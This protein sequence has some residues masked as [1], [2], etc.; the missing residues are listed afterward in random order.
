MVS[1]P[2]SVWVVFHRNPPFSL[3]RVSPVLSLRIDCCR[4]CA[5]DLSTGLRSASAITG[6]QDACSS[7]PTTIRSRR[8]PNGS[9]CP[10]H[11]VCQL[12]SIS[13]GKVSFLLVTTRRTLINC[14][15]GICHLISHPSR[16]WPAGTA[17]GIGGGTLYGGDGAQGLCIPW[18]VGKTVLFLSF[19]T[20]YCLIWC[21]IT[22]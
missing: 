20:D 12:R 14:I 9:N 1:W 15:D 18:P 7:C 4:A 5:I 19:F 3:S 21:P 2:G 13:T 10:I 16:E 11:I 22:I 8:L 17:V 6:R